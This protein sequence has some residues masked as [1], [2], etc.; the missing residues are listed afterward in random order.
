MTKH[1]SSLSRIS[2]HFDFLSGC[3]VSCWHLNSSCLQFQHFSI[4]SKISTNSTLSL[5]AMFSTDSTVS[6]DSVES[7]DIIVNI[8]KFIFLY[9]E[10]I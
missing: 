3:Q 5:F 10:N 9:I 7:I 4:L 1:R 6:I 8:E 2:G